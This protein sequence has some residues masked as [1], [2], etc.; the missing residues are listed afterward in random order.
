MFI[1]Q[2]V[3]LFHPKTG[4]INPPTKWKEFFAEIDWDWY[5]Q[6]DSPTIL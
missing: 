6:L 2:D 5:F 3:T 4:A 1:V